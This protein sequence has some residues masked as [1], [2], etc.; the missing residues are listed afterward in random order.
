MRP[1]TPEA[2]DATNPRDIARNLGAD[3]V[4]TGSMQREGEK[5]RIKY[6]VIDIRTGLE[7]GDLV[8]GAVNDLFGV[9]DRVA[10]SVAVTLNLGSPL[11]K[12]API[13]PSV[14]QREFLEAIGYLRRYDDPTSVDNAI[15]ILSDLGS[16]SGSASIQAALG[17]AYLYKFQFTH[18]PTWAVP[19]TAACQKAVVA[20]PQNP[21]VRFT[22]GE[23]RRQTG[24]IPEA[25]A[26]YKSAL[27]QQPNNAD[28]TLGLA[29][30]Y[31]AAGKLKDAE[32]AYKR[33]ISLQPQFWGGYNKLGA[34]YAAQ[35]RYP[36]SAQN[37]EKVLTLVPDNLRAYNNL[38]A[39][40]GHMG[41]YEDAIRIFSQAIEKKP[42]DQAYSNLGFCYY[43]LGRFPDAATAFQQATTLTPSKYLYWANLGDALRWIPDG[44]PRALAAYDRAIALATKELALNSHES[45]ARA[46]LAICLAKRGDPAAG[47][48]QIAMAIKEDPSNANYYKAAVIA[49]L[50][51]NKADAVSWLKKAVDSGYNVADLARDPELAQLRDGGFLRDVLKTR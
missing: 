41:R 19:A 6:S 3:L 4:L 33:A 45:A 14:S 49:N 24:Q 1:A 48:K 23:L 13:D 16:R 27:A 36:E 9:Q 22:L 20:D 46:S 2:A 8:D 44:K 39:V 31:K 30:A 18:D 21:D 7:R 50:A 40:Y 15:S 5:L 28:A 34:F 51:G 37:F 42:T 32:A 25:V 43:V 29:E 38:G 12:T 26:E 10:D 35:A 17:R 47:G 11:I